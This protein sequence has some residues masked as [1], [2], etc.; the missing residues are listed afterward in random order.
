MERS[1]G[2]WLRLFMLSCSSTSGAPAESPADSPVGCCPSGAHWPVWVV[3]AFA[4][5]SLASFLWILMISLQCVFQLFSGMEHG[6]PSTGLCKRGLTCCGNW[7]D[8]ALLS[9]PLLWATFTS[10][11]KFYAHHW[12]W[13]IEYWTKSFNL[14]SREYCLLLL[15]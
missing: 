14:V 1:F 4:S 11:T 3:P 13:W 7:A 2:N 8:L 12:S 6:E 10:C 5:G 15:L 9:T